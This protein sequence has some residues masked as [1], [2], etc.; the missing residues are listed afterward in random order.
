VVND[1]FRFG[2]RDQIDNTTYKY[3][4]GV[5]VAPAGSYVPTSVTVHGPVVKKVE[6]GKVDKCKDKEPE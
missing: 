4:V 1:D 5:T 3:M 2:D 6:P